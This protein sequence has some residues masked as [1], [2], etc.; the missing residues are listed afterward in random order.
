MNSIRKIIDYLRAYDRPV[1]IMEVCG[2]HTSAI[3]REGIRS[4]ISPKIRLVSGPGCPVCVTPSSYIDRLLKLARRPD[5]VVLS[6]G[7]LF[8]VR[9]KVD[10]L[11]SA[12]AK[13]AHTQMVYAPSQAADI[14]K[15]HPERTFVMAAVGFETTAPAYALLLQQLEAEHI[16][17]VRLLTSL[18]VT[19][20]VLKFVCEQEALDGFLAPGHVS[21]VTGSDVYLPLC[22]AYHKPFVVAGFK[23][24]HLLLAIYEIVRQIEEG[25]PSVKN[26]YPSVVTRGGNTDAQALLARYFEP[27]DADWRGIGVIPDSG[28][29]LKSAYA[30]WDAGSRGLPGG[31]MPKGCSCGEVIL[32]RIQPPS[33]PRFGKSCNPQFPLGPCM[34]S[35]EGACRIWYEAGLQ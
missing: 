1:K 32:G 6:Y 15:V 25:R 31:E 12:K 7:D 29:A 23:A 2:T 16:T 27:V 24:E 26:F 20:P 10:S 3:V 35:G 21:A 9:G 17:N 28:L 8:Q 14:A 4:L 30:G 13:G 18:K 34:V 11:A 5:T 33:C 22:E 19:P